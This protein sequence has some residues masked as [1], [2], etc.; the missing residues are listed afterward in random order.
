[1]DEKKRKEKSPSRLSSHSDYKGYY[2]HLELYWTLLF[3]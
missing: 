2:G 1:M 3:L